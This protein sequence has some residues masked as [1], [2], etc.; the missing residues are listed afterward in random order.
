MS[1]VFRLTEAQVA[2]MQLAEKQRLFQPISI[3]GRDHAWD[4]DLV[5]RSMDADANVG[6]A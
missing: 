2:R 6:G 1:S 5:A 3:D 4:V